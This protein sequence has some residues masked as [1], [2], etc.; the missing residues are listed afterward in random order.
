MPSDR[1]TGSGMP[2]EKLIV[3]L[4][5]SDALAGLAVAERLGDAVTFYRVGLGM[6]T[7][8]GLALANELRQEHGKCILLDMKLFD[9][10]AAIEAAVQGLAQFEVECLTVHGDP[11]VVAAAMA[12]ARG[13]ATRILAVTVLADLDRTALDACLVAGGSVTEIAAERAVRAL[14]AGADGVVVPQEAVAAV[15]ARAADALIVTESGGD[16][17]ASADHLIVGRA[18][19]GASDPR[20]AARD[21]VAALG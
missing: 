11:H 18:V 6:L 16:P 14:E 12:G 7:G 19:W 2:R 5:V 15:R 1:L 20:Q 8:G 10:P 17:V 9:R 21:L 13:T 3:S 4:D